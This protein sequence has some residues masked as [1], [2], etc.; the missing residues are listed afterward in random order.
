M[1][2][3]KFIRMNQLLAFYQSLLTDKQ[4][5]I[6]SLY[7]EEDQ[8]LAEIAEQFNISRQAVHDTIKRTELALEE[9]EAT[10][11]LLNKQLQRQKLLDQLKPLLNHSEQESIWR[12]LKEMDE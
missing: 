1:S 11:G 10:L 6:L 9:Y 4:Q 8:S 5:T 2:L 7:Y 12:K 3:A